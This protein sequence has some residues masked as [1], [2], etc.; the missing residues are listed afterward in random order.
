MRFK[1]ECDDPAN[2]GLSIIRDMLRP[3]KVAHPEIAEA[4][5]WC[6]AGVAA[7]EFLGG[8]RWVWV[9]VDMDMDVDVDVGVEL[10]PAS[11]LPPPFPHL[12]F[13]LRPFSHLPFPTSLFPPSFPPPSFLAAS[14]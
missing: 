2:T 11:S 10:I 13:P 9:N 6:L 3:A 5:L 7:I 14:L 4:D 1:P 8:P 12:P